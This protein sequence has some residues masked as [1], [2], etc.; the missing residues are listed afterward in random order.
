MSQVNSVKDLRNKHAKCL[1]QNK[2]KTPLIDIKGSSYPR[3][4]TTNGDPVFNMSMQPSYTTKVEMLNTLDLRNANTTMMA[5]HIA[6]KS[7][8]LLQLEDDLKK[9][10]RQNEEFE[11]QAI[12]TQIQ[13]KRIS[14]DTETPQHIDSREL[15]CHTETIKNTI[16][17]RDTHI[18]RQTITQRERLNK[19][20]NSYPESLNLS[21]STLKWL[22]SFKF[23]IEDTKTQ[24]LYFE[25]RM[26]DHGIIENAEKYWVLREFWPNNEM[27]EYFL[28]TAPEDRNF[29]SLSKYLMEKDGVLPKVLLPKKQFD[30]VSGYDLKNEVN[31]WIIDLKNDEILQKFLYMLLI[32]NH[33]KKRV[34]SSLSLGLADFKRCVMNTCDTD[35]RKTREESRCLS[36]SFKKERCKLNYYFNNQKNISQN[37]EYCDI[38]ENDNHH[39]NSYTQ[40]QN[41]FERKDDNKIVFVYCQ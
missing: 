16:S 32:P 33:L 40:N 17:K 18:L 38:I 28:C 23:D 7:D 12:Q 24:F 27:S 36:N 2:G 26:A 6:V 20:M 29:E 11:R 41:I 15:S 14:F 30:S 10:R 8:K 19:E 3:P 4:R 21:D 39:V 31:K 25:E 1:V 5:D 13:Q 35:F 37:N 9:L 22:K 34:S